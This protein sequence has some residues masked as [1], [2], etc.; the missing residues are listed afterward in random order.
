MLRGRFDVGEGLLALVVGDVF[1]LVEAGDGV[2]DVR[3]VC[4]RLF[5]PVGKSVD[6]GRE[7]V[8]LL[9]V[10][11]FVV[12]VMLPGCFYGRLQSRV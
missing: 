4:E 8:A 12:F 5:A 1:D 2:A 11:G 6:G 3:G 9:C 7:C 10:E